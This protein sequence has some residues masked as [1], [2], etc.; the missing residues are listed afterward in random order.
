MILHEGTSVA[1]KEK[2]DQS[3]LRGVEMLRHLPVAVCQFNQ[4]GNLMHQNPEALDVFGS[5]EQ[6]CA[7]SCCSHCDFRD[8]FIDKEMG[9]L[10]LGEVQQGNDYCL[11]AQQHTKG[12]PKWFAIKVRRS[13][14]PVTAETIILYSA[15]DITDLIQAK[16]AADRAN[17]EKSEFL[18]VMAHEI[19]T[20]LH[21]VNGFI[22]LLGGT[23]LSSEQHVF[24][25]L[26]QSSAKLLMT[27]INDLLDYTKLE[28]GKMRLEMIPF[29]ARSVV[30]GSLAVVEQ[31]AEEK[32]L[33]VKGIIGDNIPMQVLGDPNRLRQIL[34]NL[35]G[36]A[37]KFTHSGSITLEAS[38]VDND[39]KG[40]PVVRFVVSDT[41]IG[42][43]SE[44]RRKIFKKYQQAEASVARQYGGTGLGLA[45]C[46]ILAELM[47]GRI[48]VESQFGSG[49]EFWCDLPFEVPSMKIERVVE[50]SAS[51]EI[52][53]SLHV[54]VA[55]DNVVNQKLAAAI[56]KRMGHTTTLVDNGEEAVNEA[57]KRIFDFILMDVQMPVMDGIEATKEIRKMGNIVPIIGLTADFRIADIQN[58]KDIGMTDC[59]GKPMRMNSLRKM[60]YKT[61]VSSMRE[62][63]PISEDSGSSNGHYVH[64]HEEPF[65]R[66]RG[67]DHKEENPVPED[68]DSSSSHGNRHHCVSHHHGCEHHH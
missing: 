2:N 14:D 45:I 64:H 21:Q 18:A 41:G 39:E 25:E 24:V 43:N 42:I 46:K 8:R 17:L 61:I 44:H 32:G 7:T 56:L 53:R 19:R 52:S 65:N 23:D 68:S 16:K 47:G 66:G 40:R 57:T 9:E 36:N 60:I 49:S 22:E 62:E 5:H 30:E 12:A 13:R 48:G 63:I 20:P 11:E 37:V 15:R 31:A 6:Y 29:D 38:R 54:L 55:E 34:L 51:M 50:A 58:Y 33:F 35:L 4:D 27:V 28:A 3:A 26:L 59:M 10:V 1:F 67:H